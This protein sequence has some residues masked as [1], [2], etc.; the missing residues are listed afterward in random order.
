MWARSRAVRFGTG[1]CTHI[2]FERVFVEIALKRIIAWPD[3]SAAEEPKVSGEPWPGPA[4]EQDPPKNGSGPRIDV[5]RIAGRIAGL[6]HRVIAYRG[7]DSFPVV[8]PVE[9]AGHEQEGLRLVV[10]EGLLPPGGRRAGMLAHA[11]RPQLVGLSTLTLTGWLEV[12]SDGA[13]VY[14]PHTSKG[15]VAPPRKKLLLVSNGLFARYGIWKA[16][17]RGTAQ[18]LERLAEESST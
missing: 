4:T 6:P 11:F 2:S 17:Q 15:F 14:A 13:L 7:A 3:L 8:V 9:L 5:G 18:R 12:H 10:P 1:C 16:R